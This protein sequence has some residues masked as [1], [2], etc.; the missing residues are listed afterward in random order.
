MGPFYGAI[1]IFDIFALLLLKAKC[2]FNLFLFLFYFSIYGEIR[3]RLRQR[4]PNQCSVPLLF[5]EGTST[6]VGRE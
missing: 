3:Q 4:S 6:A 2:Y 5:A 1:K